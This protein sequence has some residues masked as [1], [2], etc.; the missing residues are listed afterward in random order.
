VSNRTKRHKT[1]GCPFCE[2]MQDKAGRIAVDNGRLR[3]QIQELEMEVKKQKV[4]TTKQCEIPGC[5]NDTEVNP[6]NAATRICL[7]CFIERFEPR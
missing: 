5:S 7:D 4:T 6:S 3:I 2:E 1:K